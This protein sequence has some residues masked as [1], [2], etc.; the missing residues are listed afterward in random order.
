MQA[1]NNTSFMPSGQLEAAAA[2]QIMVGHS[3]QERG[4]VDLLG[5]ASPMP[6]RRNMLTAMWSSH[7][8]QLEAALSV[9]IPEGADQ[10]LASALQNS[11]EEFVQ[12]QAAIM[13]EI[14]M[15]SGSHGAQPGVV[16]QRQG[17]G[18]ELF[19]MYPTLGAFCTDSPAAAVIMILANP[20]AL[21]VQVMVQ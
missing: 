5:S 21:V 10:P 20:L 19:G 12:Q 14:Q 8:P 17:T 6:H 13:A 3:A 16:N 7:R 2:P 11:H 15:Q 1:L 4:T 18:A 9:T